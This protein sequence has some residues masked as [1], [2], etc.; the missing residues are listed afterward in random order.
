MKAE[1]KYHL[2]NA[3]LA[4]ILREYFSTRDGRELSKGSVSAYPETDYYD[5]PTGNHS[6]EFTG[7]VK[8]A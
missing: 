1:V 7:E 8:H 2:T 4:E 5:R 3:E 6:F